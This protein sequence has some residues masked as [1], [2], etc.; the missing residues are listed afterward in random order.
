M[1]KTVLNRRD[2]LRAS[3][4]AALSFHILPASARG[5]NSRI[6]VGCIGV[7][8]KGY[9]DTMAT[10]AA[11]AE[12]IA[13]CDVADPRQPGL[14]R[15]KQT[16]TSES[17]LDK[18]PDAKVFKDYR[19]MLASMPGI[20]AVT[21]STP[22]HH[23]FHASLLAM[24][25]GKHVY[26]QKPISH[27][28]WE[29]RRLAEAA[30]EFKVQTQMGNQAHA[31]EPIRRAVELI[32]AGVLG[33]VTEVHAWTNRPIWPQGLTEWPKAQPVPKGLDWDLWIGPAPFREYSRE[34]APFNWRGLWDFGAGALGDMGCHIMDMPYWALGL[35]SPEWVEAK[36]SDGTA[37]SP[38]TASTV[39]YQF[40]TSILGGAVKF[41]WYDGVTSK[42]GNYLNAP[43]E[44]L[45]KADF[46]TADHVFRRFD[47]MLVGEKGRMFFGRTRQDWVFKS[48]SLTADF[49][50][51]PKTIPRVPRLTPDEP[52]AEDSG[53][54]YLEWLNAIKTG[55][56]ALSNF[57]SSGP[58]SET[59]LLGNLALRLNKRVQWDAK[60]LKA[61]NAPEAAAMVRRAYRKG[62]EL[63]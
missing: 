16:K 35:T 54:P 33:R 57:A 4:A 1:K 17:I 30:A 2:F 38:P 27:S 53:G 45:W 43:P 34:I 32:R 42:E 46:P 21:V 22:D 15:R 61:K 49:V 47:L 37:I 24:R 18:F 40:P 56:P 13:L 39:T 51:P 28:V 58:F 10:A 20:D 41:V 48:E 23:H 5:A 44:E 7:G 9:S 55:T 60:N 14:D 12:I 3:A 6:Q 31:G 63:A 29:A 62:W 19:A 36:H 59:V 26:C 11:G 25:K 8:G 52:S 50:E